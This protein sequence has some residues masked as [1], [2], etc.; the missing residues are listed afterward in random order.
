MNMSERSKTMQSLSTPNLIRKAPENFLS[1]EAIAQINQHGA[2]ETRRGFLRKSFM[3]AL[4]GVG[5]AGSG[6]ALANP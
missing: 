4:G 6:L 3:A 2:D 1:Q 5:A